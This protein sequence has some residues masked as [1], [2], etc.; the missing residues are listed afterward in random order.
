MSR[1]RKRTPVSPNVCVLSEKDDKA[2][3]TLSN[4]S[5]DQ[6]FL[7]SI[8][9]EVNVMFDGGMTSHIAYCETDLLRYSPIGQGEYWSRGD[10]G[11]PTSSD[12]PS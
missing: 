4:S 8:I 2:R 12:T 11:T 9:C 6:P 10:T 5:T 3:A 7:Y 1:S